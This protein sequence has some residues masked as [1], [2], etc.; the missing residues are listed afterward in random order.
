MVARSA[1]A[2]RAI[3]PVPP[4]EQLRPRPR[5][6]SRVRCTA[7][8]VEN[9]RILALPAKPI[10]LGIEPLWIAPLEIGYSADPKRSQISG[11]AGADAWKRLE[12]I[13]PAG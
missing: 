9:A 1:G 2:Y 10:Q 11:E 12:L 8:R 7:E 6:A 5:G 3:F 13:L 4:L